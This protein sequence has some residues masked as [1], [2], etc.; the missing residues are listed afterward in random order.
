MGDRIIA[1][2]R[3]DIA[4]MS[5]G[6]VVNLIKESGLHVRLTIGCPKEGAIINAAPT[7]PAGSGINSVSSVGVNSGGLL[8]NSA[9]ASPGQV[10]QTLTPTLQTN[11]DPSTQYF[12]RPL[13]S[14]GSNAGSAT[15]S[16]SHHQ[17]PSQQSP[18]PL[19]A[20]PQL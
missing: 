11:L 8:L 13:L 12:E 7:M 17:Q 3:I 5:H 18:N 2:N 19:P 20:P 10:S 4:G 15:S 1:V 14:G 16:T 6:D 9:Q